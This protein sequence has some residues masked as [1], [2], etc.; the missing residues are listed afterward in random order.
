MKNTTNGDL[1]NFLRVVGDPFH[2]DPSYPP[3][4]GQ[5]TAA[6]DYEPMIAALV[7]IEF[8]SSDLW[9]THLN[10]SNFSSCEDKMS[11]ENG[12]RIALRYMSTLATGSQPEFLCM[13]AKIITA[14]RRLEELRCP[15]TAEAVVMWAWTIC[16]VD[17]MDR[18]GWMLV[19]DETL[20]FYRTHG[21]GHLNDT[22]VGAIPMKFLVVHYEG[23]LCWI[24]RG[25]RRSEVPDAVTPQR[26]RFHQK[27]DV[28][29]SF[30]WF[31]Q[32]R[33]LSILFGFDFMTREGAVGVKKVE[34]VGP[35]LGL[36][37]AHYYP[38]DCMCDYP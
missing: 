5:P 3:Q 27:Y 26:I 37:L 38:M 19:M 14:I 11:T 7:L 18:D 21:I 32:L 29:L 25:A 17:M 9:R 4:I 1:P 8:A 2:F 28:H 31:C 35:S 36:G 16:V 23:S 6:A 34:E 20:R 12:K 10:R 30:Y 24:G 13:P 22:V 15:N 33:R